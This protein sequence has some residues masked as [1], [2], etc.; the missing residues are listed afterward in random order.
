MRLPAHN[1]DLAVHLLK[2]VENVNLTFRALVKPWT[3]D[4]IHHLQ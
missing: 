4:F 2:D 1:V 3:R